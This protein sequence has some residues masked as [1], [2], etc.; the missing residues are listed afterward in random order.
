MYGLAAQRWAGHDGPVTVGYWFVTEKGGFRWIG[1][2]LTPD[3][4]AD[5]LEAIDRIV[6]G[7]E[8]GLFPAHPQEPVSYQHFVP[9]DFCDPDGLGTKDGYQRW[10]TIKH[11]PELTTYLDLIEPPELA[12]DV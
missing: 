3:A 4:L 7:I 12:L 2:P 5:A 6:A 9:C 11:T 1:Y 8:R 10:L